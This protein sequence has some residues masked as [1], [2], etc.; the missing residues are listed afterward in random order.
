MAGL[1]ICL[2]KIGENNDAVITAVLS[3]LKTESGLLALEGRG[4]EIL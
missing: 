3:H 4:A 1:K 2:E